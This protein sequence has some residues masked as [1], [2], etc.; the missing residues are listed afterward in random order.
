MAAR[1]M[2]HM[3]RLRQGFTLIEM[4]I[5]VMIIAL[6]IGAVMT[7]KS[8]LRSSKVQTIIQDVATYQ[9]AIVQFKQKFGEVPGD[10]AD[11]QNYWGINP[12]CGTIGGVGT[13]TQT[14]NGNGNGLI[15]HKAVV[16]YEQYLVWQHLANAGLI[17]GQYTGASVLG[18]AS[19]EYKCYPGINCPGGL[20]SQAQT[21]YLQY[22]AGPVNG[23]TASYWDQP[24]GHYLFVGAAASYSG[25]FSAYPLLSAAEAFSLD[26]KV[27]D[28]KPGQGMW[29]SFEAT[30][31]AG[32]LP[33]CVVTSGTSSPPADGTIASQPGSVYN[34]GYGPGRACSFLINISF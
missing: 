25:G 10:M 14:C 31:G 4:S 16:P 2:K 20:L 24:A 29:K 30:G 33:N 27:D 6:L 19:P 1:S 18:S 5:V 32:Y 34:V 9:S 11:A 22:C 26:S 12:N 13:G 28:G 17:P 21:Y 3:S 23:S 7:G 15:E 8:L